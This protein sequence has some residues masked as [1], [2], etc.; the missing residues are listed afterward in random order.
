MLAQVGAA[1]YFEAGMLIC[2]GVS[3]P[4]AIAKTLRAKKVAGKSVGFLALVF[5][6]YLSGIAAKFAVHFATGEPMSW[7]VAL[8]A[9]NAAMVAVEIALYLRYRTAASEAPRK[10]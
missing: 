2:F 4:V 9:L 10:Q 5:I 1:S 7:L 8:Y 3:W 6:G